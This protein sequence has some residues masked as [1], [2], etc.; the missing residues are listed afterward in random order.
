[1]SNKVNTA[2]TRATRQRYILTAKGEPLTKEALPRPGY[3]S[4]GERW[5]INLRHT[6][7]LAIHYGVITMDEAVERYDASAEE[8]QSNIKRALAGGGPEALRLR[9][10][11]PD[12]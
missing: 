12:R 7:A 1:M 4:Q 3:G 8:W 9:M 5:T 6:V 11:Q 2:P 10:L